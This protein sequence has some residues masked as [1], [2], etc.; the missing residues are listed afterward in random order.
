MSRKNLLIGSI[1]LLVGIGLIAFW[2]FNKVST[3]FQ[4]GSTQN[5]KLPE[6]IVGLQRA[7]ATET[8]ESNTNRGSVKIVTK[9]LLEANVGPNTLSIP[10]D[11]DT[12]YSC[13]PRFKDSITGEPVDVYNAFIDFS[14]VQIISKGY[15]LFPEEELITRENIVN[16]TTTDTKFLYIQKRT[17]QFAKIV[18]FDCLDLTENE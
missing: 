6:D 15:T 11:D 18:F 9:G 5:Q 1:L 14:K 10:L 2:Q 7:G 12:I 3:I 16:L 8:I 17:N 4:N 13:M